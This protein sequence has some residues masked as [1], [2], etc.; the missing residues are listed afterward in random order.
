[1]ALVPQ[2]NLDVA[3]KNP[4]GMA[5]QKASFCEAINL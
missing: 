4:L 2:Y 5:K 3:V 1:L